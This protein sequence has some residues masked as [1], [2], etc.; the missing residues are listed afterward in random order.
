MNIVHLHIPKTAGKAL[1]LPMLK[2]CSAKMMQITR[3]IGDSETSMTDQTAYLQN[4]LSVPDLEQHSIYTGHFYLSPLIIDKADCIFTFLREPLSRMLSYIN[5]YNDAKES[6][7]YHCLCNAF[8]G[9]RAIVHSPII[10]RDQL[11]KLPSWLAEDLFLAFNNGQARQLANIPWTEDINDDDLYDLAF[12][13]LKDIDFVGTQEDLNISIFT[14][15]NLLGLPR[16]LPVL[17]RNTSN[18]TYYIEQLNERSLKFFYSNNSVDLKLWVY[19]HR[20]L[21]PS[22]H[23]PSRRDYFFYNLLHSALEFQ[24]TVKGFLLGSHR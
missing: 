2:Y 12:S 15:N 6:N 11:S 18:R 4:I 1:Y 19:V 3:A 22:L 9:L 17:K 16:Y 14:L 5:Y 13:R 7:A 8:G 10:F 20:F 21:V 24:Y 23:Q